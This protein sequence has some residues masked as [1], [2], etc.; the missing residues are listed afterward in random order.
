MFAD[1]I[2]CQTVTCGSQELFHSFIGGGASTH[3]IINYDLEQLK[4]GECVYPKAT[5]ISYLFLIP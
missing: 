2:K 5:D 3:Q 1:D 4:R